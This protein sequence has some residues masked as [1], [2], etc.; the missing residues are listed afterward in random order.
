MLG[1]C[2]CMDQRRVNMVTQLA[3]DVLLHAG[4][5]HSH[6]TE[7]PYENNT[8]KKAASGTNKV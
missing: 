2:G 7:F 8:L 5:H 3:L 6:A 4:L 1:H